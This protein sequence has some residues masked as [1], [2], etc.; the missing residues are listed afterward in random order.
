M[1]AENYLEV[2][3][4]SWNNRTEVHLKSSFYDL[5]GF[6]SGNTSLKEI[7]LHLL[8]DIRGK[9]LL[10]LQC[11][12]GQDTISLGRMG[13]AVTGV[14]FSEKAI[15]AA[16]DLARKAG[17]PADFI[18]CD[19]YSLPNHC[20]KQF[21]IV[22][23]S[24]GTIGWL[25]DLTKWA[26]VISR[27]LKPGGKFIMADFHPVMWMFDNHFEKVGYNYFN[28]EPIV[29]SES[30]TYADRNAAITVESV[31]WNHPTS[32]VLNNLIQQGLS[33]NSF[34]EFD[35]SPYDIIANKDEFE[36]GKFR[37]KHMGNKVP[38]VFAIVATKN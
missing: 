11:H 7:E 19:L 26:Q 28:A 27:F 5:E 34:D 9:S 38:L 25:P 18:C 15:E 13:A 4:Q 17:I 24:Y 8:G 32:E 36:P 6:L 30:G 33:I 20:E 21:D 29:E 23:T 10:H 35:Y 12:F 31:G 16:R 3:K 14:D 22:F 1:S 2:N 37:V